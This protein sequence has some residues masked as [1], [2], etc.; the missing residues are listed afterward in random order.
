MEEGSAKLWPR[1]IPAFRT[2]QSRSGCSDV[3]CET[4]EGMLERSLISRR[5]AVTFSAPWIWMKV[6]RFS[7]GVLDRVNRR[8]GSEITSELGI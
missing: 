3:T 5:L 8:A 4:N 2:T 6:S 1:W 7:V